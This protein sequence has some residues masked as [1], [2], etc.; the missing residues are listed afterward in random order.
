MT[1]KIL[2]NPVIKT[3]ARVTIVD[4]Y[5]AGSALVDLLLN[6]LFGW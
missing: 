4:A 1:D 5:L 3:E 2:N 6:K